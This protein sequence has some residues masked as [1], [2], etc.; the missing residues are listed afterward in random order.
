MIYLKLAWR[1]LFRNKRRTIIAGLAIGLG[2]ASLIFV[3]AFVIGTTNTMLSIATSS[4]LGEAQIHREGFREAQNVELTIQQPNEV[5]AGLDTESIVDNYAPRTFALGM[6][7]SPNNLSSVSVVGIEPSKEKY[8]SLID[9]GITKGKYFDGENLQDIV[10]GEKL[11]ELLETDIGDRIVI[12]L[13]QAKTGD[14][15]QEMFR[16]SGIYDVGDKGLNSMFAFIRLP[17]AQKMLNIGENIHEI[18]IKFVDIKYS[19]NK[20]LSFWQKY[21][22]YG[23][24]A[25][26]W[27]TLIPQMSLYMQMSAYSTFVIALMLVGIVAFVILNTLFMSMY[28]RIFEFGVL[29]AVGTRP[30]GIGKLIIFEAGALAVISIA[31]GCI[32]GFLITYAF[33]KIG[34]NYMGLSFMNITITRLIYPVMKGYQFIRYPIWVFFFTI[35]IGIYP[36]IHA[37]RLTP[38][39]AMKKSF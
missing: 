34:I 17:K 39:K 21:S 3:D 24:E 16:V 10:I 11:A 5:M 6:I 26:S 38:A 25:T 13:A 27:T 9:D 22:Q 18:A 4:F 35:V 29:K 37:A 31:F 30:F 20:N 33:S 2:L 36:A 23:N 28:E 12:T 7:T 8:L 14:L 19:R 1:N 15:V 32:I